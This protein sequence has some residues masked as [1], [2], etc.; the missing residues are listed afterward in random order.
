MNIGIFTSIFMVAAFG[1]GWA[2]GR[3]SKKETPCD[4]CA[5]LARKGGT[6]KYY[7]GRYDMKY[8][9]SFDKA[10]EYCKYYEERRKQNEQ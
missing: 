7:C 2:T 10:P 8:P 6:W 9:Y 3:S 1:V 4:S 5:Y